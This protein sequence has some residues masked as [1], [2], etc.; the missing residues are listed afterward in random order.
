MGSKPLWALHSLRPVGG[1][2]RSSHMIDPRKLFG[3]SPFGPLVEHARKVHECVA[4]VHP[5]AEAVLL[6]RR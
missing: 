2:E 4:L 6:E 3:R 5:L 1:R